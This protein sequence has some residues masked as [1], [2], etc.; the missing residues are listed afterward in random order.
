[1]FAWQR[2]RRGES[3]RISADATRVGVAE[4]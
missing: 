1:M 2:F 4:F 3:V